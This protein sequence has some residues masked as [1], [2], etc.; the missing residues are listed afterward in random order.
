MCTFCSCPPERSHFLQC[1]GSDHGS[2]ILCT[3]DN[4]IV[5]S[6]Y[7]YTL[8]MFTSLQLSSQ[9]SY[10]VM[11]LRDFPDLTTKIFSMLLSQHFTHH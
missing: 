10:S 3:L 2:P 4:S 7:L 6:T 9:M 1:P 8:P 5:Y 11:L